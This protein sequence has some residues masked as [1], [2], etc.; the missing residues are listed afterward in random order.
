MQDVER[1]FWA[2][3]NNFQDE[4]WAGHPGVSFGIYAVSP[5]NIEWAIRGTNRDICV[6]FMMK[7][8]S[9]CGE[10]LVMTAQLWEVVQDR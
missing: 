7:A 5:W 3:L 6:V 10:L 1:N 4:D 8:I 2:I 9:G